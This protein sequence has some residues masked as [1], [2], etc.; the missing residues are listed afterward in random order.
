MTIAVGRRA[1]DEPLSRCVL[2]RMPNVMLSP[3]GLVMTDEW[4]LGSGSSAMRAIVAVRRG[5]VPVFVANP[6]VLER[7][8]LQALR[9][10]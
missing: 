6:A 1:R 4:A 9:D 5:H 10:G 7:P 2:T 8:S 3:N